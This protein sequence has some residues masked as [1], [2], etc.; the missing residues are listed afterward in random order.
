MSKAGSTI[1]RASMMRGSTLLCGLLLLSS[2]QYLQDPPRT[3]SGRIDEKQIKRDIDIDLSKRC[4]IDIEKER[5]LCE[6]RVS[7]WWCI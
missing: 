1:W 7:K 5:I 3:D 4:R 2:C 6:C